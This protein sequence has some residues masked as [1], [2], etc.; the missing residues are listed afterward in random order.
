LQNVFDDYPYGSSTPK[1]V[2]P[3]M[4][5]QR[6]AQLRENEEPPLPA[7]GKAREARIAKMQAE[8]AEI[9]AFI[10]DCDRWAEQT[11]DV[12]L[13]GN[14]VRIMMTAYN[15]KIRKKAVTRGRQVNS[16]LQYIK[17]QS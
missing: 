7:K 1:E 17:A 3:G 15:A 16:E 8:L 12:Q 2:D 14:E 6:Q 11:R 13:T 9:Q 10:D 4:L 5:T